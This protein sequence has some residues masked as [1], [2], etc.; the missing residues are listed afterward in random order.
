MPLCNGKSLKA[1]SKR[2]FCKIR[3]KTHSNVFQTKNNAFPAF[4]LLPAVYFQALNNVF[5]AF[6]FLKCGRYSVLPKLRKQDDAVCFFFLNIYMINRLAVFHKTEDFETD[7]SVKQQAVPL[8]IFL[9]FD[10]SIFLLSFTACFE[11]FIT[12][13]AVRFVK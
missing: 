11:N 12:H 10:C 5:N 6:T 3:K 8:P 1:A 4:F 9:M 13:L 7:Y 2:G